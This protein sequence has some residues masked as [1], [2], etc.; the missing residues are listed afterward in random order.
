MSEL[1]WFILMLI[2]FF[3]VLLAFRL[4]GR[5]GLFMWTAM[6]VIL[7]NLQVLKIIELFGMTAT[8]GN[9]IYGSLFL[10]T[11]IM[12]ELY[13]EKEARKAVYIGFFVLITTMVIM[14]ICLVFPPAPADFI[15]PALAEVFGFLPRVAVAS[16]VAYLFSQL[17]DV[18]AYALWRKLFPGTRWLWIR[19][20][21]STMVSQLLD[22]VIFCTL[23][24]TGVYKK[25]VFWSVMLT[26][27][28]FKFVTAVVD[29]PFI[30]LSIWIAK[31]M[32]WEEG[33]AVK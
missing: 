29:T 20:N 12:N 13:G 16:L 21:L 14:Q 9:I 6:G 4:F 19:N 8:M 25:E 3:G 1:L 23:A 31:K 27:Y 26:T 15:Q 17:H 10:V 2:N 18:W 32:G 22:T 33:N 28:L 11:D 24:F 30:Y 7:A 5:I